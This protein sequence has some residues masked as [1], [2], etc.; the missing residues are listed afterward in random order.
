MGF[1]WIRAICN[2]TKPN[3]TIAVTWAGVVFPKTFGKILFVVKFSILCLSFY[4]SSV[5]H[6]LIIKSVENAL[7]NFYKNHNFVSAGIRCRLL[8]KSSANIWIYINKW[9][10]HEYQFL[11]KNTKMALL[12]LIFLNLTDEALSASSTSFQAQHCSRSY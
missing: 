12:V 3:H 2:F 11:N 8:N 1:R 4:V 6:L 9:Q 7:T 10:L 5:K